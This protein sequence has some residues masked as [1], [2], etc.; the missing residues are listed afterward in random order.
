MACGLAKEVRCGAPIGF[1][2]TEE[3]RPKIWRGS[4]G[5]TMPWHWWP[6]GFILFIFLS[7]LVMR[8]VFWRRWGWGRCGSGHTMQP[9]WSQGAPPAEE[10][11]RQRLAKGEIDEAEYTRIR[12]TLRT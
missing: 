4:I 9:G 6:F 8:L 1:F 2:P 12:D 7:F 5:M 11:L 3:R 10:I